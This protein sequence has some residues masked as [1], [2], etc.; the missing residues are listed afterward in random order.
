ML[1][2]PCLLWLMAACGLRF[3][4]GLR[5]PAGFVSTEIT[6]LCCGLIWPGEAHPGAVAILERFKWWVDL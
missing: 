4:E 1:L 3:W 2:F 6:S 5:L